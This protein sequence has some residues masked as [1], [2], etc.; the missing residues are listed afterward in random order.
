M[1]NIERRGREM[2]YISD[3]S[4]MAEQKIVRKLVQEFN[5]MDR[6][7]FDGLAAQIK[8][9]L[10]K[11]ENAFINPPFYCDYGKNIELGKNFFGN[12]NL[13]I[14]DTG[15]VRIGD[16]CQCAPNVSIYT[17]GH[18]VHPA[19]RNTLYEYGI[20]VTIGNNVWIGGN[21]VICPGVTIGDNVVIGAG[22]VVTSLHIL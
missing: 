15:K 1:N 4:V 16:N 12:Y 5:T 20:D 3:D 14:L 9:I 8:K 17:A 11:S 7:D 6:S 21:V 2:L 19:T 10:G 22:S 13:T 18:P